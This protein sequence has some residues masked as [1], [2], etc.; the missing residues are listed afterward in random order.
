MSP[1]REQ[2]VQVID[3]L[4]ETEQS[5]LLE[6]ANRFLGDDIATPQDLADIAAAR[7][8]YAAGQTVPHNSMDW[9]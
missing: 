5:L 6:I 8:D 9:S 1:V 4:P 2:L 7:A 3:C